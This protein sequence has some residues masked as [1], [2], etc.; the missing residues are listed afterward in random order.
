MKIC[1][2]IHKENLY[3]YIATANNLYTKICMAVAIYT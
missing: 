2:F 1:I 3:V